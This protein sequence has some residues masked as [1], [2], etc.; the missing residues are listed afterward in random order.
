MDPNPERL[1]SFCGHRTPAFEKVE[2]DDFLPMIVKA[3]KFGSIRL[4][5]NSKQGGQVD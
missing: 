2:G 3:V 1:A 4:R 5:L